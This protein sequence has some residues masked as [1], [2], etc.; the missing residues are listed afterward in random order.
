MLSRLIV[1]ICVSMT[2]AAREIDPF[3]QETSRS[4][5]SYFSAGV[6]H[7]DAT[8]VSGMRLYQLGSLEEVFARLDVFLLAIW[9]IEDMVVTVL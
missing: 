5:A 3:F 4:L 7:F 8:A 9:L 6:L 1:A 2:I